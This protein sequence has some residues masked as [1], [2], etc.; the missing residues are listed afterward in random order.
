MYWQGPHLFF[1]RIQNRDAKTGAMTALPGVTVS[2]LDEK[3]ALQGLDNAYIKFDNF[4]LPKSTL[5]SRFSDIDDSTGEYQLS[6]PKGNKRMLDLLI[7]RLMTGRVCLSEYTL[8]FANNLI[9]ESYTYACNRDLW[10]SKRQRSTVTSNKMSEKP[11]I[12]GE[13]N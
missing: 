1:S 7:S 3:I 13:K 4:I 8:L 2:S 9:K 5:L 10:I 12:A 6:L 11:L